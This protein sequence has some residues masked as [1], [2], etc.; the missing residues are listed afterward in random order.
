MEEDCVATDLW[1]EA[2]DLDVDGNKH[3]AMRVVLKDEL[4]REDYVDKSLWTRH[5]EEDQ[6]TVEPKDGEISE[7]IYL[8]PAFYQLV[9]WKSISLY[10]IV[11]HIQWQKICV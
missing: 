2:N 8:F 3:H 6:C 5:C 1:E 10:S 7:R 9:G 11:H 4:I